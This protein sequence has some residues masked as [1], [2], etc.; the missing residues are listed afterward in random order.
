MTF[1]IHKHIFF[2]RTVIG[3]GYKFFI[4]GAY[5]VGNGRLGHTIF[6]ENFRCFYRSVRRFIHLRG[7]QVLPLPVRIL[8][9]DILQPLAGGLGCQTFRNLYLT[10]QVLFTIFISGIVQLIG[11]AVQ[12]FAHQIL[13][14]GCGGSSV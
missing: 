11:Q 14:C 7:I 1:H 13:I 4:I 8:I 10:G 2:R 5:R 9:G 3:C 6:T 12:C